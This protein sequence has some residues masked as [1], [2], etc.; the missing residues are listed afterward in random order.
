MKLTY[1]RTSEDLKQIS[2]LFG[3]AFTLKLLLMQFRCY[4]CFK[5]LLHLA[6]HLIYFIDHLV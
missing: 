4:D 5:E 3:L 1:Q 6:T 2:I